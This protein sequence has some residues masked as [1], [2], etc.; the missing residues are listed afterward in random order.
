MNR[1]AIVARPVSYSQA[2]DTSRPRRRH[3]TALRAGLGSQMLRNLKTHA[4]AAYPR[5][6]RQHGPEVRPTG[7]K[8]TLGHVGTSEFR[9]ADIADRD[10]PVLP[11]KLRCFLVQKI[12]APVANFGVDR[13]HPL[14]FAG[15]LQCRQRRFAG[16]IEGRHGDLCTCGKRRQR[17]GSQVNAHPGIDGRNGLLNLN[18]DIDVPTAA[19]V[20]RER[21]TA[22]L[23]TFRQ[24]PRC[25]Q[26][27]YRSPRKMNP[28]SQASIA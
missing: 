19:T 21:A 20:L 26:T 23:G 10:E 11:H 1:T 18:R 15:S 22:D 12:L 2:R 24:R 27:S 25:S 8:N 4:A 9:W 28:L 6:P 7:V 16:P 14:A 5:F 17:L 13:L 3:T